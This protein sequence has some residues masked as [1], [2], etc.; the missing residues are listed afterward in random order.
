MTPF[1][2]IGILV[3]YFGIL[4]IISFF[5]SR[6]AG[7]EAFFLG[8]K[9]SPWFL[10][11][12]GM[13]GASISG[14][15]FISVPGWVGNTQFSYLQ[16]VLG[17][18][19]GYA[20][21]AGILLPLYYRLNLTSIYSYL[22]QRFGSVS[23]KTGASFFL[24]SRLVGASIRLYLV[25]SVL[26]LLV[27]GAWGVPFF[28]TVTITISLIWLYTHKGGIRTIVYTD[29]FQ[30]FFMLVAVILTIVIIAHELNLNFSQ[31][32][33]VVKESPL[34]R[35]WFFDNPHEK[36][37]FFKQFLSGVFI[38]IV[39]TGLD[40]DSM[41][42]NLSC[43]N[44]KEA[45]KNMYWYGASFL[46]VNLLFLTLGVLLY[47]YA[48]S[49]GIAIPNRTDELYPLLATQGQL[50]KIV[51]ILFVLG[52]IAAAYSSAD[53]ALTALTT[54]FSIDILNLQNREYTEKKQV[55]MRK[56]VHIGISILMGVIIMIFAKW[57]NN[58]VIS[59]LLQIAGY[60][61]GP[62]L[63]M[64]TFGLFTNYKIRDR[65]V[66]IVAILSPLVCILLNLFSQKIF[67]GYQIG[68]ELLIINGLIT[69]FG[70]FLIKQETDVKNFATQR[71]L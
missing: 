22:E 42:K 61:Y 53:S 51:S 54:S 9:K 32:L 10:V 55:Q 19:L 27:F 67:F 23:Y 3:A 59:T 71:N 62:L 65:L 69:F 13:I 25:S 8:N 31:M 34:S 41:Q 1:E 2:V 60:T 45:K 30:T 17:Y 28:V 20:V 66:W 26:Q 56:I 70:L 44:L 48:A 24:V 46:P 6:G 57:N 43:R 5:T 4:L 14:V 16:M 7:N 11:A 38:T 35:I 29:T 18:V 49:K 36:T 40:Q 37:Y 21:V 64:Y 50:P 39:M 47:I 15:T 63:G 52:L 58:N 68:F 12:F 33:S